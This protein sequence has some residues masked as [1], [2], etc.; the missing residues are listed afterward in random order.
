MLCDV[1]RSKQDTIPN[2]EFTS[3]NIIKYIQRIQLNCIP[4]LAAFTELDAE[5][6]AILRSAH[7]MRKVMRLCAAY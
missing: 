3:R 2:I 6:Q 4:M 7:F 5:T 1:M